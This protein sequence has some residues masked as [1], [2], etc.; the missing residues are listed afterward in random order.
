MF[1]RII[2]GTDGSKTATKA[3]DQAV[4]VAESLGATLTIAS[5]GKPEA[6]RKVLD[7]ETARLR[8][9][10]VPITTEVLEGDPAAALVERA[11]LGEFDLL[12]VGNKGMTGVSRFTTGLVSVPN[13]VSHHA[14]VSLLIVRTT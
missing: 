10:P 1:T 13:K 11:E 5:A 8:D 9:A 6:A 12:V 2:V 7:A 3:V 4:A 14:P